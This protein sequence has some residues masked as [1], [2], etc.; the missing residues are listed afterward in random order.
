MGVSASFCSRLCKWT[1]Q[2]KVELEAEGVNL[3]LQVL[4]HIKEVGI[5]P[6]GH[7]YC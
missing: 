7:F 2:N 3:T 5:F 4:D 1:V 6:M